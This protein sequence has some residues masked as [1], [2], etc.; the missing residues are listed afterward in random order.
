MTRSDADLI[1]EI[2]EG[3]L[4]IEAACDRGCGVEPASPFGVVC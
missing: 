4:A 3:A 2:L 1:D